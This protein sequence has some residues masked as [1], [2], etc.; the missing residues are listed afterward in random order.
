MSKNKKNSGNSK[1]G[2]KESREIYVQFVFQNE[3]GVFD[4]T[5]EEL[6]KM[7]KEAILKHLVKDN[8]IELLQYYNKN[9]NSRERV[10]E[11][12]KQAESLSKEEIIYF[13]M[14]Y[15]DLEIVEDIFDMSE[16]QLMHFTKEYLLNEM[17]K[18]DVILLLQYYDKN[19]SG[20]ERVADLRKKAKGLSKEEIA[21]FIAN[22]GDINWTG[23][24]FEGE[25][26]SDEEYD[27]NN[28]DYEED[29]YEEDAGEE[30]DEAGKFFILLNGFYLSED[31]INAVFDKK[32]SFTEFKRRLNNRVLAMHPDRGF[33]SDLEKEVKNEILIRYNENKDFIFEFAKK[34]LKE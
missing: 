22:Y 1:R 23:F 4:M 33:N 14:N 18:D 31:F 5:E 15:D 2:R 24:E 17:I 6:N 29:D 34:Y 25:D 16:E 8:V 9:A 3:G 20:R 27:D 13:I 19:A 32:I 12:R 28:D 30:E 10:G 21:Y 7:P 26:E 11:L